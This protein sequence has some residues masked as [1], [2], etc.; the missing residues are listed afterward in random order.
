[1][2]T[3]VVIDLTYHEHENNHVFVGSKIECDDWIIKQD[4]PRFQVL[5]L[6]KEELRIHNFKL[7]AKSGR[8][9][10]NIPSGIDVNTWDIMTVI[11]KLKY[12]SLIVNK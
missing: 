4:S 11:D 10:H 3:H 7:V 5:P 6:T 1:M 8:F 9:Y 2:K 12:L